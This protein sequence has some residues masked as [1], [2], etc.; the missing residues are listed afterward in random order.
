MS[1][2]GANTPVRVR[3]MSW[4]DVTPEQVADGVTRQVVDGAQQ[5]IVR[6]VY[7]PGA[8]FPRHYHPQEQVT[9]VLSGRIEFTIAD[10]VVT[11][12]PDDLVVI[13][14]GVPHG[15]RVLGDTVVESINTLS[16][17]RTVHPDPS[18]R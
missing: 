3:G 5:T 12:G 15:A 17:R 2:E 1:N 18:G 14:G 16:P 11:L 4:N 6:Y 9:V 8:V 7:Q 10:E 13:P